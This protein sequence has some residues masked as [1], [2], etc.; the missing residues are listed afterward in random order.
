MLKFWSVT[1]IVV[2]SVVAVEA[3]VIGFLMEVSDDL[4][5][6][7]VDVDKGMVDVDKGMVD[8]DK[9][10]VDVD[11]GMVDVEKGMVDVEKGMVDVNV[12]SDIWTEADLEEV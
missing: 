2:T 8:V 10:M 12:F 9:G 4:P 11:K 7:V 3:R 1:P 5:Y 6:G